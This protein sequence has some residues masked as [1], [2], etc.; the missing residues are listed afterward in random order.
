MRNLIIVSM[1]GLCCAGCRSASPSPIFSIRVRQ[2]EEDSKKRAERLRQEGI[3]RRE[4]YLKEQPDLDPEIRQS[5]EEAAICVG[6]TKDQVRITWGAPGVI[7]KH[8]REMWIY[9]GI[10]WWDYMGLSQDLEPRER[11]YVFFVNG[12][13]TGWQDNLEE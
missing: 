5:I 11:V 8:A 12:L 9:N 10:D 13:V 4:A 2:A 3:T 7:Q 1:C 6:M